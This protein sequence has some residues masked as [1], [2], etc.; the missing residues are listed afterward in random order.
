MKRIKV[1]GMNEELREKILVNELN[2][3]MHKKDYDLVEKALMI[4]ELAKN[5]GCDL[6]D[7]AD[8]LKCS[9]KD[10]YTARKILD[11]SEDVIAKIKSGDISQNAVAQILYNL[12][13]E[14][15][16]GE[17]VDK[18]ISDGLDV[19]EAQRLVARVNNPKVA[20]NQVHSLMWRF[21]KKLKEFTEIK[22]LNKTRAGDFDTLFESLKS[23][24]IILQDKVC[25][26]T[27][28]K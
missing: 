18:V 26:K 27:I 4:E 2:S 9:K 21:N 1:S 12:K 15:L 10:L 28:F 22:G 5:R 6:Q 23:D 17:V 7:L 13:D 14:S 20:V 24:L 8:D 19:V 3:L 25:S 11:A 16:A